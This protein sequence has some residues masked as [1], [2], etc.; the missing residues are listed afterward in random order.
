MHPLNRL[1]AFLPLRTELGPALYLHAEPMRS[2]HEVGS[3]KGIT[4]YRFAEFFSKRD[5]RK[6]ALFFD[7]T[8][9]AL[10]QVFALLKFSLGQIPLTQSVDPQ[11]FSLGIF[12]PTARCRDG[13]LAVL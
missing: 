5:S 11:D 10:A 3:V 7:F 8:Q 9:G 2:L 4:V 12:N 6:T 13:S 1:N